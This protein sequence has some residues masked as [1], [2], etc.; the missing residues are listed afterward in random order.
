MELRLNAASGPDTDLILSLAR[1]IS[2][3]RAVE[4]ELLRSEDWWRSLALAVPGNLAR[5]DEKGR[6]QFLNR[7]APAFPS[8][9]TQGQHL[10]ELLPASAHGQARQALDSALRGRAASF[11]FDLA[12]EDGH[13]WFRAT[14]SPL[15]VHDAAAGALLHAQDLT[16]EREGAARLREAME[17]AE[18]AAHFRSRFVSDMG[19][20]LRTPLN[21]IIGF[22]RVLAREAADRLGEEEQDHLRH[23][24]RAAEHVSSLVDDLLDLQRLEEGRATLELEP[25]ELAARVAEAMSMVLPQAKE[26]GHEVKASVAGDP[27]VIADPRSLVQVLVNLLSNAIKFTPGEG[28]IEVRCGPHPDGVLI[29]VHDDGPGIPE[30]ELIR[31]FQYFERYDTGADTSPRGSG[32]GLALTKALIEHMG[33]EVGVRSE[34]G[35]GSVFYFTLGVAPP[36]EVR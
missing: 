18:S 22:G 21:S 7:S 6:L 29:E 3:R 27:R 16:A 14:I 2:D 13:H 30:E 5:L 31:I 25:V 12:R 33:G 17:E 1:D 34:V 9:A 20:E 19:H 36:M 23:L 26:R 32:I 8:G 15:A 11:E 28:H 4:V 10:R 35:E 24:L